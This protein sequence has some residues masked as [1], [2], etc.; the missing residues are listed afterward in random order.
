MTHRT[1]STRQPY[2]KQWESRIEAAQK[3]RMGSQSG[4]PR[5]FCL[6]PSLTASEKLVLTV[7]AFNADANGVA[8]ITRQELVQI[9]GIA[10]GTIA[11][12]MQRLEAMR[13]LE[14]IG[15]DQGRVV[16]LVRTTPPIPL[17]E[18]EAAV[19]PLQGG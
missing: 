17:N 13:L 7:F 10:Q 1:K 4:S 18:L 15:K 9:T 12:I 6:P 14:R 3:A 19:C 11:P 5:F 16:H 2:W 8:C